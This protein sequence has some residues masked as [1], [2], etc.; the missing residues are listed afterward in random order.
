MCV[1]DAG[2]V[3][4]GNDFHLLLVKC[5][6]NCEKG[7]VDITG[8]HLRNITKSESI[9]NFRKFQ[10]KESYNFFRVSKTVRK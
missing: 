10:E 3:R 2:G 7:L 8:G 5:L 9:G 4:L 1:R 6:L